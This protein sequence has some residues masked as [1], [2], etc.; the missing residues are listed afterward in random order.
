MVSSREA[1]VSIF[2]AWRLARLDPRGLS[3]FNTTEAGF[4]HSFYA[5]VLCAPAY[6]LMVMFDYSDASLAV[7]DARLVA[8]HAIG[9]VISWTAFPL[10]MTWAT[11]LLRREQLYIRYIVVHNWANVVEMALFLPASALAATGV[12][13]FSI[14]PALAAFVI[15]GYQWYVA[16]AALMIT[17]AQAVTVI[18]LDLLIDLALMMALRAML[19]GAPI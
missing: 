7:S 17:G 11:R 6:A 16:R 9:Y 4:W 13:L 18:G 10:A 1:A 12:P 3:C 15:F 8:V 5:G 14:L 2:G 19:P